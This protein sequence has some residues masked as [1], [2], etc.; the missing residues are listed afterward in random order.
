MATQL[1]ICRVQDGMFG[2]ELAIS[3]PRTKAAAGYFVPRESVVERKGEEGKV[4]VSVIQ[5]DSEAWVVL[6][7]PQRTVIQVNTGDLVSA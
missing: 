3:Y 6:P 4:K 7:T 2:D 5:R 1:L